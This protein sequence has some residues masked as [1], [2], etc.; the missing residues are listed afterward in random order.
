MDTL[1]ENLI[2]L[3]A[4]L[5]YHASNFQMLHWNAVGED[6]NDAHANISTDYYKLCDSYIDLTAEM[7]GRLDYFVYD[8][9][10][11][12]QVAEDEK[13]SSVNSEE[14]YTRDEVISIS[15]Q[16]LAEVV[17]VVEACLDSDEVNTSKNAGIRSG[18][19]NM[20]DEFDLQ[21]RYVNKRRGM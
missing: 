3:N 2:L 12:A 16:L 13:W 17:S 19:E 10:T 7:V 18:L 6:F 5:R 8:Y 9:A 20:Q 21:V 4:I 11:V 14:L 15:D 1:S